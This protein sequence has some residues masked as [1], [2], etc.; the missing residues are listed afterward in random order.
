M[1]PTVRPSCTTRVRG[2]RPAT[3]QCPMRVRLSVTGPAGIARMVSVSLVPIDRPGVAGRPRAGSRPRP[4]VGGGLDEHPAGAWSVAGD[5][6]EGL[7]LLGGP[8]VNHAGIGA[9]DRAPGGD[10]GQLEPVVAG[11]EA[12]QRDGPVHRKRVILAV[13]PDRYPSVSRGSP[14][15]RFTTAISALPVGAVGPSSPQA[16]SSPSDIARPPVQ[17]ASAGSLPALGLVPTRSFDLRCRPVAVKRRRRRTP[18]S[19]PLAP[20]TAAPLR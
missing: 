20:A 16:S 6:K 17:R 9:T 1:V 13:E 11:L 4:P 2:F 14:E 12:A 5:E 19:R 3:T 15:V 10:A 8:G 18:L 7:G